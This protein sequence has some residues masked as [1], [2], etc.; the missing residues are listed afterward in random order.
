MSEVGG[1]LNIEKGLPYRGTQT[2][3]DFNEAENGIWWIYGAGSVANSPFPNGYGILVCIR[4]EKFIVQEAY[5]YNTNSGWRRHR[6][7]YGVWN[8]WKEI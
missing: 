7:D 3:S 8:G 5:N 1:L 6:N 2:F 4:A